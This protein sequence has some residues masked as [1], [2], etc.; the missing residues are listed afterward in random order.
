M[1]TPVLSI[2]IV[3][4]NV[5]GDLERC[6]RSIQTAPKPTT[7]IIVVDACS[8]D[9]TVAVVHDRFPDVTLLAQTENVGF[10]KGNNIGLRA[11][12][13]C[14]L[15]LLNP[16]T[17]IVGDALLRLIDVMEAHPQV[18]VAGAHT[19]NTDGTYQSTRRHFPTLK[20]ELIESLWFAPYL[21]KLPSH[22][23]LNQPNC[24]STHRVDWVQGSSMLARRAVYEQIG[25]LDE[26]FFMFSE[27]VDWC[28]RATDAGWQIMY[29]GTATIIHHGGR[30]T[31]QTGA[32]THI[33]YQ[34]SKISYFRKHYGALSAGLLRVYILANYAIQIIIET[35][36]SALGHKSAM[37]Q[38]RIKCYRDVLRSG[39]RAL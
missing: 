23:P 12:R 25:G 32:R 3:S 10:T 11:A 8:A 2:I 19:L 6:L 17:E 1:T 36:K 13:G 21:K 28:K 39:L 14:Y 37:R 38:E 5:A 7:E 34:T 26:S 16:D 35:V 22:F 4:W 15:L 30:S 9:D 29:V 33:Y 18:G 27:E 24:D 31:E 20:S